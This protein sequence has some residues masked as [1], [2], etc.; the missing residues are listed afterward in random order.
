[1]KKK[2]HHFSGNNATEQTKSTRNFENEANNA[3]EFEAARINRAEVHKKARVD[4]ISS[5]SREI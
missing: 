2:L 3:I 1:M 4:S 5:S